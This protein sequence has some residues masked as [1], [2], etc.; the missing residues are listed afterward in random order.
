ML[1]LAAK[2][3]SSYK[4][5]KHNKLFVLYFLSIIVMLCLYIIK[6]I[7]YIGDYKIHIGAI[8]IS[9]ILDIFIFLLSKKRLKLAMLVSIIEIVAFLGFDFYA[10]TVIG[11]SY[12]ARD[13]IKRSDVEYFKSLDNDEY[14][15]Y[16]SYQNNQPPITLNKNKSL[17][18][19]FMATATY[20]SMYDYHTKEFNMLSDSALI[21]GSD[22]MSWV[23]QCDDP[24]AN[25]M[26]GVKYYIVYKED[27]LPKELEFEYAYN[28][29]YLKVYKNLNYKGFGFTANKL[30][31][32]KDFNNT[33]D[34]VDYI[35]IDDENVDISKYKNIKETKL[36]ISE[37]YKN[38]FKANIDLD[39]DNILL[40]PIPNNKGWKIKVNGKTVNPI[41]VNGGFI[42]L[43]L[44]AGHN[45]IEMHFISP[46]FKEGLILSV[47]G[48]CILLMIVIKNK[49]KNKI[50]C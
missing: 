21:S 38:Y 49:R 9:L 33:K 11:G 44:K 10:K 37:R 29:D 36:N 32:I 30:K 22:Y 28:L 26:L 18:Y 25:T 13:P 43:E 24:Y 5:K 27:E 39:S 34:F 35:L 1:I 15:Y 8:I 2:G 47:V 40:I 3:L 45:E 42:G 6:N 46:Y 16:I 4:D 19:G 31:Y 17:D 12:I 48:S 41:S 23:L 14:R 20:N 7:T 50:S